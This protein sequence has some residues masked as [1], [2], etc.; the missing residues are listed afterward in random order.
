[1]K[2]TTKG[3]LAIH[4]AVIIFGMTA[5]FSQIIPFDALTISA[6]RSVVAAI[7][8]AFVVVISKQ[9]L[10]LG[11][12]KRY[13]LMAML[14]VLL[15]GHWITYFHSMQVASVAGGMFVGLIP[16]KGEAGSHAILHDRVAEQLQSVHARPDDLV[17]PICMDH[18]ARRIRPQRVYNLRDVKMLKA[19]PASE[20]HKRADR[21]VS[22][23]RTID[24][25]HHVQNNCAVRHGSPLLISPE[26]KFKYSTPKESTHLGYAYSLTCSLWS[27]I[28]HQ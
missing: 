24:G 7:V 17:R 6:W 1:M 21:R 19:K 14:G 16:I 28:S 11:N 25:S 9:H 26:D 3:L 27:I 12:A 23:R 22:R 4:L 8:L 15:A 5:L 10:P 2:E 18:R 13:L 20:P